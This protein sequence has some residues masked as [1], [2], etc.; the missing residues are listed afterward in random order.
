M[1]LTRYPARGEADFCGFVL[2]YI[3]SPN[4]K[5]GSNQHYF[6]EGQFPQLHFKYLL[7]HIRTK[8]YDYCSDLSTL[9]M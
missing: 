4:V 7:I 6:R 9:Y 8:Y 5:A 3:F 2:H 1:T